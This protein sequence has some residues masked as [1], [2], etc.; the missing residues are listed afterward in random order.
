MRRYAPRVMLLLALMFCAGSALGAGTTPAAEQPQPK[1]VFPLTVSLEWQP[2]DDDRLP[3]DLALARCAPAVVEEQYLG[4]LKAGLRRAAAYLYAYSEGQMSLGKVTVFTGGESWDKADIRILANSA[5][6]PT[7]FVG[8]IVGAPTG[9]IS[10]TTGLT[11]TVFYP[12]SI[13]LGRAWDGRGARCGA[14]S[15]PA[16]WRTIGHEWGHYALFLYDEYFDTATGAEQYCTT[17]GLAFR[18]T[19]PQA[20]GMADSVMAYHYSADKLWLRGDAPVPALP[21]LS[22]AGTPQERAHGAT[23]WQTI[24]RFYPAVSL[25]GALRAD[26]DFES[27]PAR[28]LF[29]FEIM[30]P[31]RERNDTSAQVRLELLP[32]PR[33]VG[34]SYLL[35]PGLTQA[36]Q[37]ILGQGELIPGEAAALPFWGVQQDT[38][39]RAVVTVQD[40]HGGQR[41]GFPQDSRAASALNLGAA[42]LLN[43]AASNWR[44]SL[45]ITPRVIQIGEV[46]EV[47]GL[48]VK[49]GHCGVAPKQILLAYCPAGGDCGAPI[50]PLG[51]TGIFTHTFFFPFDG[52]YEP[53]AAHGYIYVR[54]QD[55]FEET[56]AWY[57]LAGGVGPA[58]SNVHAP[59]AEGLAETEPDALAPA[60]DN[61][62][63]YSSAL[64]CAASGFTLPNDVLGIV[65]TPIDVQPVVADG[66]G[67]RGWGSSLLDPGLR[68]RLS[69]SQDLLDRLQI[70]ERQ[71]VV[72][73]L[74]AGQA[75]WQ[76]VPDAGR[77]TDL[78]WIAAEAQPFGGQGEVYALGY[79]AA[80]VLLPLVQ[81]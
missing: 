58:T 18:E 56:I 81:R 8:G 13:L 12:G 39:D 33:L 51:A 78:D 15:Q 11:R 76:V 53:P 42:N 30:P 38:K 37:R 14:W 48:I 22:C 16:G 26:L 68:V 50:T 3:D 67:G 23:D 25:P 41:F 71:L 24:T 29:S 28:D 74:L 77:S 5:Y 4:D 64:R 2:G 54:N 21:R 47:D 62:L 52:Q 40:W 6:R 55:T 49:V 44:P 20:N 57:Q 66:N 69:Y 70:D 63:L 34:Q 72:L 73:R 32:A 1:V 46:S 10:A 9:N 27:S 65:G 60:A 43:A 45:T 59:L 79:R 19:R 80:Q 75:S 31:A 17:T 61:L 35:R 36:P 7:S